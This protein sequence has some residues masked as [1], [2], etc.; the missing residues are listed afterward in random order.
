VCSFDGAEIESIGVMA[1]ILFYIFPSVCGPFV[2]FVPVFSARRWSV[3]MRSLVLNER[4]SQRAR[5]YDQ[6]QWWS[7]GA[8]ALYAN[9]FKRAT[10]SWV[11]CF[12]RLPSAT[13]RYG[14]LRKS[15][16]MRGLRKSRRLKQNVFQRKRFFK[17]RCLPEFVERVQFTRKSVNGCFCL[18]RRCGHPKQWE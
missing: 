2:E 3:W 14:K 12:C 4:R 15:M 9:Q 10:R 8:V 1:G 16:S 17:E 7:A 5:G 6:Q 13:I 18:Q 11:C